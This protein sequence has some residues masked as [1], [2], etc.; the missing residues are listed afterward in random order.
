[1]KALKILVALFMISGSAYA[2]TP[3]SGDAVVGEA[4][5][6]MMIVSFDHEN[7]DLV[8]SMEAHADHVISTMI[9]LT[10]VNELAYKTR[11]YRYFGGLLKAENMAF[12]TIT[13]KKNGETTS[14][15]FTRENLSSVVEQ[16]MN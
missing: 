2:T 11:I 10:R 12:N 15:P 3:P 6:D 13:L 4:N 7:A 8:L 16:A 9:D 1:M 5:V 14:V